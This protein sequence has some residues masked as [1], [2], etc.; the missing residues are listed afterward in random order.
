[1][2]SLR[3]EKVRCPNNIFLSEINHLLLQCQMEGVEILHDD[4]VVFLMVR[5]GMKSTQ[6]C[7]VTTCVVGCLCSVRVTG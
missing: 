2:V 3:H 6:S 5:I 1:M 4:T 7:P